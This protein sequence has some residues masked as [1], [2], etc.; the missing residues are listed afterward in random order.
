MAIHAEDVIGP[1]LTDDEIKE[2]IDTARALLDNMRDRKDLHSRS[3]LERF[4][5]I[6]MGEIAER[7]V[8][9]WIQMQ[10]KFAKSAVN[11][12]SGQPDEGHDIILHSKTGNTITC[13]VKSSLS[14]LKSNMD[15][16]LETF[17]LST[18]KSE[19]RGINIQ[20]YFWLDL[21]GKTRVST[22]SNL[23][24]AMIGWCG[25]KDLIGKD[26]STY[27][28]ENRP[29]MNDYLKELRPMKSLL[30]ILR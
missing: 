19:I 6:L 11:K 10:G 5:N 16:I 12:K 13:S 30:D 18:K 23:N 25:R 28:T 14:A 4:N 15:D 8:I 29:V 3:C 20:V 27:A 9:K 26:E 24:M 22:P 7:S 21:T 17:R 2:C 1:I